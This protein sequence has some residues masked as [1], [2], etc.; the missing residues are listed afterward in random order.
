[1]SM[2]TN[3]LV[4]LWHSG[5]L[6]LLDNNRSTGNAQTPTEPLKQKQRTREMRKTKFIAKQK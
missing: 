5:A 1:M 2:N 6:A 4:Y 3:L